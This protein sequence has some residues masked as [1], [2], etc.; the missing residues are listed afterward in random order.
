MTNHAQITSE[1]SYIRSDLRPSSVRVLPFDASKYT[2]TTTA[3]ERAAVASAAPQPPPTTTTTLPKP[4]LLKRGSSWFSFVESRTVAT[5][6]IVTMIICV[7]FVIYDVFVVAFYLTR[8]GAMYFNMGVVLAACIVSAAVLNAF[9]GWKLGEP[10]QMWGWGLLGL[11]TFFEVYRDAFVKVKYKSQVLSNEY[12]LFVSRLIDFVVKWVPM[13]LIQV[14]SFLLTPYREQ[15]VLSLVFL[16]ISIMA[17]SASFVYADRTIDTS[18]LNLLNDPTLYGYWNKGL[19]PTVV[20]AVS[21]L[22][23]VACFMVSKMFS[24]SLLVFSSSARQYPFV[25]PLLLS[26]DVGLVTLA[27]MKWL[28]NFRFPLRNVDSRRVGF[29]ISFW[30]TIAMTALPFPF[31]RNPFLLSYR[32]YTIT[33]LYELLVNFAYLAISYRVFHFNADNSIPEKY[34]FLLI[35]SATLAALFFGGVTFYYVPTSHRHTFTQHM[36]IRK[37]LMEHKFNNSTFQ[38]DHR[39]RATTDLEAIKAL[40]PVWCADSY[41]PREELR[42]HYAANWEKWEREGPVW[43]DEK[44]VSLIP[45]DLLPANALDE[46]GRARR[47]TSARMRGNGSQTAPQQPGTEAQCCDTSDTG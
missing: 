11:K 37:Y 30:T 42:E 41:L 19:V 40:F 1:D 21:L 2:N 3:Q 25:L 43:F 5:H 29:I 9:S 44:F 23:A 17:T 47:K 33:V 8:G 24:I 46:T 14:V 7:L 18:K 35:L 16:A 12:M 36:P 22:V 38:L 28:G 15:S 13:S 27:K 4:S 39:D 45:R 34:A 20:Q 10:F 26:I 6:S 32:M 31:F